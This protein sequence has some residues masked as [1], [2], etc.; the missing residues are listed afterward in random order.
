MAFSEKRWVLLALVVACAAGSNPT[1][2]AAEPVAARGDRIQFSEHELPQ[3]LI[4]APRDPLSRAGQFEALSRG[5]S[6]GGVVE[7]LPGSSTGSLMQSPSSRTLELLEKQKNWIYMTEPA[8]SSFGTSAEQ[9]LGVRSYDLSGAAGTPRGGLSSFMQNEKPAQ[10]RSTS[11]PNPL[12]DKQR[13]G[14]LFDSYGVD[15]LAESGTGRSLSGF[16]SSAGQGGWPSGGLGAGGLLPGSEPARVGKRQSEA[17][18]ES[19]RRNR[20]LMGVNSIQDLLR[21]PERENPLVSGFDPID[22]RID[23]TR[24]EL[25]P[26]NPQRLA[27]GSPNRSGLDTFG[28][29]SAAGQRNDSGS[30][31]SGILDRLTPDPQGT[32]SLAPVVRAPADRGTQPITR[33]GEFPSRRF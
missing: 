16:P 2:Y 26:T 1:A 19:E 33:F 6:M 3:N 29:L 9:A 5:G 12:F 20:S 32:A 30:A 4:P 28:N 23:T 13:D 15:H 25:N 24:Q 7:M 21:S 31:I 11:S 18:L 17:E 10:R 8:A 14:L 27:D 22:F